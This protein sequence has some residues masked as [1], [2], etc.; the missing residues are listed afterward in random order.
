M[1][2]ELQ[3]KILELQQNLSVAQKVDAEKEEVI[4]QLQNAW[5]QLVEHWKELEQQRQDL[6][7]IL[8]QERT[9]ARNMNLTFTQVRFSDWFFVQNFSDIDVF[10]FFLQKVETL[11]TRLHETISLATSYRQKN[12]ELEKT[13]NKMQESLMELEDNFKKTGE[14]TNLIEA[15]KF[16]LLEQLR[17]TTENLKAVCIFSFI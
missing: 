6:A 15:E 4:K 1:I 5:L 8:E 9:E 12:E 2:Q 13:L 16:N 10:F 7:L 11:E 14:Y 17:L 3:S